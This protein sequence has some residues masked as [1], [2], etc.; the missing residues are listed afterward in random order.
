MIITHGT[1]ARHLDSIVK[2]GLLP[3]GEDAGNWTE[4]PS[5]P[6]H[7]YLTSNYGLYFAQ[8]S[9]GEDEHD[10]LLVELDETR[11]DKSR[12]YADEDAIA[13]VQHHMGILDV[14]LSL[15]ELTRAARE[16]IE[17]YHG[18]NID[19]EWSME[20]LGTCSHRGPIPVS[21]VKSIV[22]VKN[23][24]ATCVFE[25]GSDPTITIMNH[26]ILGGFYQ[27]LTEWVLGDRLLAPPKMTFYSQKKTE[28]GPIDPHLAEMFETVY[29]REG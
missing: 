18:R 7:V 6:G 4:H 27:A 5:I 24:L 14:S 8:C 26:K 19:G 25:L 9:L 22:L 21:A 16:D 1:S 29:R 12:L 20:A 2:N 28:T 17:Y 23:V 3:R 11:L 13:Q 15:E 10:G